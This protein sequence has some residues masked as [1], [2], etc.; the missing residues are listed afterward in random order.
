MLNL[1]SLLKSRKLLTSL[2][3][4]YICWFGGYIKF[5]TSHACVETYMFG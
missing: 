3:V 2:R 4:L 5:K 1:D